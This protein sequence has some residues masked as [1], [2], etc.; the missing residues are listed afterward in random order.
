[1]HAG[2]PHDLLRHTYMSLSPECRAPNPKKGMW[3]NACAC[4]Q[5]Q[6]LHA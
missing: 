3:N 1:M 2:R 4:S 5:R 6:L